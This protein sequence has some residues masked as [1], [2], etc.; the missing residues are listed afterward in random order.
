MELDRT[1]LQKNSTFHSFRFARHFAN[2]TKNIPDLRKFKGYLNN[3]FSSGLWKLEASWV[4]NPDIS[5]AI[6][7]DISTE[8]KKGS[9]SIKSGKR[10]KTIKITED[11]K[12]TCQ[13]AIHKTMT[14]YLA[15]FSSLAEQDGFAIEE[16]ESMSDI[17]ET[18]NLVLDLIDLNKI[19]NSYKEAYDHFK[20]NILFEGFT[21]AIFDKNLCKHKCG[22]FISS[23]SPR[24]SGKISIVAFESAP[25]KALSK[26]LVLIGKITDQ[27]I[28]PT[29]SPEEEV[30]EPYFDI[31]ELSYPFSIRQPHL[32]PLIEKSITNYRNSDYVDCVSALGL[33]GEDVLT[34]IFETLYRE[35]LHKG[36]TLGQLLDEIQRRANLLF[37]H[38]SEPQPDISTLYEIIKKAISES[39]DKGLAALEATRQLVTKQQ[40]MN[41]HIIEKIDKYGKPEQVKSLFPARVLTALTELIRFRNASSHKSRIPIGPYESKRCAY[42]LLVIYIWWDETKISIDWDLAPEDIMKEIIKSSN[43]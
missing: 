4:E 41:K 40:A 10:T 1:S 12:E 7:K 25:L 6:W 13:F 38:K 28:I 39:E 29:F 37:K 17:S 5:E 23:A 27:T 32:Y 36:L 43:Q 8:F 14:F 9:L 24:D 20:E 15:M 34:Q 30:L 42:C 22:C 31:L 2:D 16:P 33:A 19:K 26:F 3:P 35:Q 21:P 11:L 18:L